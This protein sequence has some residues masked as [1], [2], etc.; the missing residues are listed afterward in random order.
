MA[1]RAIEF[2]ERHIGIDL[3]GDGAVG[4]HQTTVVREVQTYEEEEE[5]EVILESEKEAARRAFQA[6]LEREGSFPESSDSSSEEEV[7][8]ARVV[9]GP[10]HVEEMCLPDSIRNRYTFLELLHENHGRRVYFC[11][12]HQESLVVSKM[13]NS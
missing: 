8:S 6:L 5:E 3:D 10:A 13:L 9:V 7:D 1:G 11:S 2:F 4:A 12:A